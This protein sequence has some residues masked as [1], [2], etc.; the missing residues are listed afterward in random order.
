MSAI[1]DE[2]RA[3]WDALRGDSTPPFVADQTDAALAAVAAA[4]E[5]SDAGAAA[6]AAI[7]LT[8][9]SLDLQ[10]QHLA[11]PE[12]DLARFR[13]WVEQLQLDTATEDQALIAGDAAILETIWLRV[14]HTVDAASA[15]DVADQLAALRGAADDGDSAAAAAAAT[16]LTGALAS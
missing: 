9:A 4:I 15:G 2:L 11:V 5:A 6:Q 16:A 12:V 10:L 13:L 3:A 1:L 7:D 14:G 8:H